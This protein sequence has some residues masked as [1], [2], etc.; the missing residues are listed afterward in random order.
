MNKGNVTSVVNSLIQ[1]DIVYKIALSRGVINYSSL[2]NKIKK[3]VDEITGE[4]VPVNTI[5]KALTRIKEE[6][7]ENIEPY[8]ALSQVE[9]SLEYGIIKKKIEYSSIQKENPLIAFKTDSGYDILYKSNNEDG[10]ALLKVRMRERFEEIPG[11]TV[12]IISL[13][14]LSGIKISYI[15]RFGHEIW[16]LLP[17]TSGAYALERLAS[18]VRGP[19]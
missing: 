3:L 4:D 16:F 15:Y 9:I 17:K 2:G 7:K 8:D 6:E 12:L 13:L 1:Q 10:L 14:D 11:I 18:V 5:V 19:K